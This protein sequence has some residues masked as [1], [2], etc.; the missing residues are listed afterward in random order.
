MKFRVGLETNMEGRAIAWA[1]E[2]PG[3][4]AYGANGQEALANL[5]AA[6]ERYLAWC[7][8]HGSP[9]AFT[10]AEAQIAAEETFE[11]TTIDEAFEFSSEVSQCDFTSHKNN[12]LTR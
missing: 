6:I 5:P 7:A 3:C 12:N 11:N 8:S 10:L 2:A 1:L 4:F 9:Q